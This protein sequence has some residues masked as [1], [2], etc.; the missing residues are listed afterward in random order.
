MTT[1]N[2][3]QKYKIEDSDINIEGNPNGE[4]IQW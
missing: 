4:D 1:N 2:Y 3:L